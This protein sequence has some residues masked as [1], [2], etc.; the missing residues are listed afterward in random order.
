MY[1]KS[2]EDLKLAPLHLNSCENYDK[3]RQLGF[4]GIILI[5]GIEYQVGQRVP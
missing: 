3:M 2:D 5:Y 1:L 4:M